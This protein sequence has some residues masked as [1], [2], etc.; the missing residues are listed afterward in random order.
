[1]HAKEVLAMRCEYDD[2]LK[3]RYTGPLQITKGQEVNVFIKEDLIP[4]NIKSDLDMALFKNS[5]GDM[6]DVAETVTK[7]F[8]NRACIHERDDLAA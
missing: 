2:G 7:T 3:V 4:G 6:R 5:C 8:G 1:M